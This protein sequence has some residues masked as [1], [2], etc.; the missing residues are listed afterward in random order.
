MKMLKMKFREMSK[1]PHTA[2]FF[3]PLKLRLQ[4]EKVECWG[5]LCDH[6]HVPNL[7]QIC[8]VF[9]CKQELVGMTYIK[10]TDTIS[11]S[12][13]CLEIEKINK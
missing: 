1:I 2:K 5:R 13:K 7:Q 9:F 6:L 8:W 12:L 3:F 4:F 11:N 10:Q